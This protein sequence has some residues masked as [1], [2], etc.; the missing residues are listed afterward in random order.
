MN[1]GTLRIH[2]RHLP[3]WEADGAIYFITFHT[4]SI[5]LSIEQQNIVRNHIIEGNKTFY[6]LIAVVVMPDH[7][8]ILMTPN[9]PYTISQIMKGIK[10]VTARICNELSG[11]RGKLWQDESFDRIVRNAKELRE[12]FEYMLNNPIK[13]NLTNNPV[14]YHGWWSN[15]EILIK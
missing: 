1:F 3:H 7:V 8:H 14:T 11:V 9:S 12:K 6:E 15:P 13:K 5:S 10:G 4:V 2:R